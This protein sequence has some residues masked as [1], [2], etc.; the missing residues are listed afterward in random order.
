MWLRDV[1]RRLAGHHVLKDFFR[2][3]KHWPPFR[4]GGPPPGSPPQLVPVA[5][6]DVP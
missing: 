1:L 3:R 5:I 6:C 4:P 2:N